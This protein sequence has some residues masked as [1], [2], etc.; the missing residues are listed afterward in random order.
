MAE[1]IEK[2]TCKDSS[3]QCHSETPATA[4]PVPG[5]QDLRKDR[6][7]LSGLDCADCAEKLGTALK[8]IPGVEQVDLNFATGVLTVEHRDAMKGILKA[9]DVAGYRATV[10][11]V[12]VDE[13]EIAGLD[14]ADCA[15]KLAKYVAGMPGVTSAK[16]NFAAA[17][18]TVQHTDGPEKIGKAI[19]GNGYTYRLL[20]N[21]RKEESFLRKN[22]RTIS[23]VVAGIGLAA[24]MAASFFG[25]P[26]YLPVIA[27]A[28]AIATGGFY[29]F[30]S[31]LYSARTLTPDMNLLMT[32]AVIGAI[33]LNLWEEGAAV[34]FLFSVGYALQSYTL[35]RTRNAI[36]SLISLTPGE[37][38]VLRDGQ[39][40]RVPARDIGR[41]EVIVI[42]PGARIAMDGVVTAGTSTVNQA[43]ITGEPLPEA[44]MRGSE[45][46]AGTLNE[47]GTLEVKVTSS[48]E[49]NTI[50]KIVHMVEEAQGRK[51]PAQEFVDRFARYYTPVV[52]AIATAIAIIPPLAGQPFDQWF[53]RALV[54][55]VIACPCA[56]VISTP[57]SIVAA[58]GNASRHGLLIKGGTYLEECSRIKA[59]AFDKTGTLTEGRPEVAEVVTFGV[60]KEEAI[61][62]AA[63]IEQRSEHP[64]ASA[65]MR[66]NGSGGL[67]SLQRVESFESMPGL[68]VSAEVN[69][70][71][72]D[73]GGSRMFETLSSAVQAEVARLE[74]EGMTTVLLSGPQ[75]VLA[76]F[77][78]MD[79]VRGNS[80]AAVKGLHDADIP[81]LVMLTGDSE[82]TAKTIAGKTGVDEY[83]A[84]LLPQDKV[85][86]ITELKR[87]YGHVAM[88]GDGV[89]D[90]PALAEANIG[91]AMGATGSDT[92]IETADIALMSNDLTRLEYLVRLG[93]RTM[94]I[95]WQNVTFSL[96][97]KLAFIGLTLIG[98]SNLWL[99]MFAD[100]GAAIIVILN[101]MRL[102]R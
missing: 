35:D 22:R 95:I 62:T 37:A 43:P 84:G 99:A 5:D 16:M 23:A 88:V 94:G 18:L 78:I 44:K 34:I 2:K 98:L 14:C 20:N 101:G 31:A 29:I 9:I 57:V 15:D 58:I 85:S 48:F 39:E 45:V 28:F 92:A 8:S 89:N 21:G 19:A 64:L 54:L 91:I 30:R 26:W 56:L 1:K 73:I 4:T 97:I 11:G 70:T 100:T 13:F 81:H 51:A 41:G 52:L 25:L 96:V 75:G 27:F 74:G 86:R 90:A 61:R 53:Y 55:L 10:E 50:T 38:T 77:G 102:L 42:K 76:I 87:K 66:A 7:R 6:I 36:K 79:R 60:T 32:V 67:H 71:R 40:I 83:Y 82:S 65:I 68:G 72:F 63:A 93:R 49:D 17:I 69:G 3:C 24:G 33:L 12:R 80:A 59:I 46:Y 47:R